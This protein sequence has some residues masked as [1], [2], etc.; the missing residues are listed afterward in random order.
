[1]VAVADNGVIG[2]DNALPWH[3]PDDLK[4]F[5]QLTLGKPVVMGR[6]TFESIGKPLPGRQ[7]I[8]VTRDTNYRR[9][10]ITV[11]HDIDAAV[12]AAVGQ[13]EIMVIGGAELFRLFLPRAARVHLTRVHGEVAGDV[14]WPA[15]DAG[16][17][18]RIGS[19]RHE[20]DE[21]HV[22]AMTFEVWEKRP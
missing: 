18:K 22:H 16:V 7:N 5:K 17:W 19:E 12:R 14:T 20:A 6:K 4:R 15:L 8:V 10:G 2:R 13:P 11:V 21:R 3:L 1:M 9:E